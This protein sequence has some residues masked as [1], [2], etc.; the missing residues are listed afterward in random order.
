MHLLSVSLFLLMLLAAP[1]SYELDAQKSELI[2]LTQPGGLPGAAHPHV[3]RATK[4]TG[5]IV[6]DAE[7]PAGSS[8]HVSFPTAGLLNDESALR[9]R[10][11]MK[12]MSDGSREAV[13]N[14]MRE[15]DQ[16]SPKLFPTI[17]FDSTS[18]KG[19]GAKLEVTGK[20]SLRGVEKEISLPVEVT[21]KDGELLGTGTVVVKHSD[22][23]FKPYSAA[24]GAVKNLD[25]ITLKVRL[26]GR[27]KSP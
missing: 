4:V 7:S 8:V 25:E 1:V 14:N 12:D 15:E 6:Y 24:F 26:V 20:L 19:S 21:V 23:R 18:I 27:E 10:E 22:F 11:G 3:V 5:K 17:S 9:K 2:G 13:G 16:L